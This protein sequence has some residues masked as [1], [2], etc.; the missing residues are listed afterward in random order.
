MTVSLGGSCGLYI[1]IGYGGEAP[2][3]GDW[4]ATEAGSRYL[5]TSSRLVRRRSVHAQQQR[6]QL[7]C[8]RLPKDEPIPDD[9]VVIWLSWYR[10]GRAPGRR[11]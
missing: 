6:Y 11:V 7:R 10:R 8:D 3:P 1:D 5:V 4:I 2:M 9:V